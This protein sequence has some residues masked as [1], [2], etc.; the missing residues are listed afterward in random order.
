ME[1]LAWTPDDRAVCTYC[2]YDSFQSG[3]VIMRMRLVALRAAEEDGLRIDCTDMAFSGVTASVRVKKRAGKERDGHR[4]FQACIA[5]VWSTPS[6]FRTKQNMFSR[7]SQDVC[8]S[9]TTIVS[10]AVTKLAERVRYVCV[11]L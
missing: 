8:A 5:R 11:A 4:S 2:G 6:F 1:K 9:D 7:C 3:W 10:I